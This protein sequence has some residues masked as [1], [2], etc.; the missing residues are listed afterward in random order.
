MLMQSQSFPP[1]LLFTH[2]TTLLPHPCH[3]ACLQRKL[4]ARAHVQSAF[5]STCCGDEVRRA[6]TLQPARL[7]GGGALA[8]HS[9][10][11][12]PFWAALGRSNPFPLRLFA[13]RQCCS[14]LQS[15]WPGMGAPSVFTQC[16]P[17]PSIP[18]HPCEDRRLLL[19]LLPPTQP[20][21][22]PPSCPQV[23]EGKPAPECF[24]RIAEQ[25]GV[26]PSACLVIEDSPSG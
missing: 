14:F 19:P 23:S 18:W 17:A 22:P 25:T 21:P 10:C 12:G 5:T 3:R 15:A 11:S 26:P 16:L 24:L 9:G 2:P 8:G 1:F 4:A 13:L 6:S 7:G 20:P